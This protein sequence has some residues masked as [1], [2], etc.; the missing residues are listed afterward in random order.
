MKHKEHITEA[1]MTEL[2]AK[3]LLPAVIDGE[4]RKAFEKLLKKYIEE[5]R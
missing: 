2:I 1:K 4:N 3:I 5:F